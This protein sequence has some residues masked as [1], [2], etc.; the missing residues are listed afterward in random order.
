MQKSAIAMFARTLGLQLKSAI[1]ILESLAM[2][3]K[4]VDNEAI[5]RPIR[6]AADT[7]RQGTPLHIP[8]EQNKLF[9]PLLI[10]MMAIGDE[11]GSLDE[12]LNK[13]ADFYEDDVDIM[14]DNLKQLIEPLLIV[15]L[16]LIIG[17]IVLAVIMPMFGIYDLIGSS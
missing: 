2:V 1:P 17:T 11:T 16:T 13:V 15:F 9:P 7:L 10:H 14:A 12:M 4:V 8:L 5:S 6:E 3:S